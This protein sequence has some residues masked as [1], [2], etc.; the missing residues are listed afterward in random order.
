MTRDELNKC[1]APNSKVRL[2]TRVCG[3]HRCP[4]DLYMVCDSLVP[5][6]CPLMR[7]KGLVT[8]GRY[9]GCA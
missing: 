3:S 1:Y 5:R 4:C 2:A 8:I 6:P 7:K 9:L